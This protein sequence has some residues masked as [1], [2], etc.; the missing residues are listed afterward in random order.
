VTRRVGVDTGGTFTDILVLG[1]EGLV[2]FKI[3]STPES[4]ER[5]VL[6][7]AAFAGG[8]QK[9]DLIHS[10]TVATNALLERK[11]AIT[12]LVTTRGFRD[13]LEIGRQNRLELYNLVPGR[14]EPL[15]PRDRRFEINERVDARGHVLSPLDE[16]AFP[17]LVA[18]LRACGAESVAVVFLFSFLFPEHERR[19]GAV[20]RDAGFTVSLSHEI[21]PEFREYERGSTTVANA[22]VRP[23]LEAYLHRLRAGATGAASLRI[24]QSNGGCLT[25]E[26][27]GAE[28]VHTLLSGPAAGISGVLAAARAGREDPAIPPRLITFDMGGTSTD[29]ALVDGDIG[30]STELCLAGFPIGVPMVDVHT[31]GAGG[32]SVASLDTGGALRVGPESAGASPGPA[33]YGSFQGATV[34]DANVVLGRILPRFFLGG[35]MALDID[36]SHAALARLGEGMDGMDAPAAA[37]E[38]IR[39][40][41]AAMESAIRVISVQRGHDPRD[42]TL[43]GFG[44]AGGLHVFALAESLDMERVLVPR[45]PGVL[46]ALG[47]AAMAHRQETSRTLMAVW[48]GP[49]ATSLPSLLGEMRQTLLERF[50][51]DGLSA[52]QL[53]YSHH[54]DLRY[55]GQS[56]ELSVPVDPT[57]VDG[58]P[59]CF[60]DAHAR[61]YGHADP[62]SPIEVVTVRVVATQPG[63]A[64]DFPRLAPRRAADPDPRIG[65]APAVG[66]IWDRTLLRAGDRIHGPALVVEDYAT[67]LL[68]EGWILDVDRVGNLL[69]TRA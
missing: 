23:A 1:E 35:R 55:Q 4:Y 31:I 8:N 9:F 51:A 49:T 16:S 46:S 28:A 69:G 13:V 3:P 44:G 14:T 19:V 12:A 61:R 60:H 66:P 47:A 59:A 30:V 7:G 56:F 36:R 52:G 15:V 63:P 6:E 42:F 27:A 10:T 40:A 2:P 41:N 39:L 20:L 53:R 48:D 50:A 54:A 38:V 67:H 21:L 62:A 34:T 58:L 45:H 26:R 43:V 32:G 5:A 37:R 33:C 25:P 22:Y 17:A 64:V 11:G 24:V 68:P 57:R 18:G 29:V 65:Y